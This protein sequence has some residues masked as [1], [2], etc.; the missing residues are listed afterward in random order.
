MVGV[1]SSNLEGKPKKLTTI[2]LWHWTTYDF[3]N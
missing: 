2:Y 3:V 1:S